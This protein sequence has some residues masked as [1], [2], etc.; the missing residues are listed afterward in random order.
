MQ[1]LSRHAATSTAYCGDRYGAAT[2]GI[3]SSLPGGA[4]LRWGK[5]LFDRV[6]AA[7][8]LFVLAPVM[9]AIAMAVY[10]S[11]GG[12][13]IFSQTRIG[14]NGSRFTVWKFRSM[15]TDRRTSRD[16]FHGADRRMQHKSAADP[17]L[18]RTG[19]LLRT[20]S[21]DELPQLVNVLKGEMSLVGPRP[22]LPDVVD[23]HYSHWQHRRHVVKP[24]LTGLW[25]VSER[26]NGMM[27]EHVDVD[28]DY[29]DQI[30]LVTDLR[31]ILRTVPAALASNRGH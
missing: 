14:K 30:G 26:G 16:G 7:V 10:L 2:L 25:Q 20:L 22:E 31:I 1:R 5:S 29:V 27:H 12:P 19:R 6:G 4:Y 28:L 3:T 11:L 9:V 13:V 24:G 18:T 15:H 23:R 8:G 17:R 21:L